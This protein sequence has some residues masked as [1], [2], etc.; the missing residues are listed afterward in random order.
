MKR[1][2]EARKEYVRLRSIARKRIDRLQRAGLWQSDK[3][4]RERLRLLT[5]SRQVAESDLAFG[6]RE[7]EQFL[8][9]K[10]TT[11]PAAREELERVKERVR[12]A[13]ETLRE[14]AG[15]G[16]SDEDMDSF[17]RYMDWLR[18]QVIDSIFDSAQ[19]VEDFDNLREAAE[20][21]DNVD[22]SSV[23]ADFKYWLDHK[24]DLDEAKEIPE[25]F[26]KAGRS[27]GKQ[28]SR[29]LRNALKRYR[30]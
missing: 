8:Y 30:S 22:V 7:L 4:N 12:K 11:L 28:T 24:E 27:D 29:Q 19:A 2:S 23:L 25:K 9:M 5:P 15:V 13:A 18:E 20:S 17:G 1:S 26:W 14:N 10:P 16:I 3:A 21:V 6:I